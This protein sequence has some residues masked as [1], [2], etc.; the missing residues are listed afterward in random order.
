MASDSQAGKQPPVAK[1]ELPIVS[2]VRDPHAHG[3]SS[4]LKAHCRQIPLN[5]DTKCTELIASTLRHF[6]FRTFLD[7]NCLS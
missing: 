5:H 2:S 1:R 4:K 7:N 3:P 6:L